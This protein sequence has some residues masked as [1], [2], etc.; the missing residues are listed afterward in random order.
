[1]K[2]SNE[3][4]ADAFRS[5]GLTQNVF[6]KEHGITLERLRYYLYRKNRIKKG[7]KKAP[8]HSA[9]LPAFVSFNESPVSIDASNADL[10]GTVTIVRG[11]FTIEQITTLIS[12]LV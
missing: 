8:T 3:N 9:P 5:S 7:I 6:C 10:P 2:V 12:G 1:M 4:L 11:K